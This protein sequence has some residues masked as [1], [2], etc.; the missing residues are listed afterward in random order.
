MN[1]L[2]HQF[3]PIVLT[4][5]LRADGDDAFCDWLLQVS[6]GQVPLTGKNT[7]PNRI[8]IPPDMLLKVLKDVTSADAMVEE[9]FCNDFA[10]LTPEELGKRAIVATTNLEVLAINN[11]IIAK[12]TPRAYTYLRYRGV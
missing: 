1:P 3:H 5:N 8:S 12:F 6:T 11:S 9:I 7:D 10:S 2:W 4:K